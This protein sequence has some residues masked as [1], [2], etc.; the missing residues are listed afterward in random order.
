MHKVIFIASTGFSGSTMLDLMLSN[1]SKGFSCGEIY[2]Y[3]NPWRDHHFNP[4]CGCGNLS[5]ALWARLKNNYHAERIYQ[6]LF[7]EFPNLEFVV[8]SSKDPTWIKDQLIHTTANGLHPIP[9][10]LWKDPIDYAYSCW[11]RG[12]DRNWQIRW[13]NYYKILFSITDQWY[14]VRYR[15]LAKFPAQTLESLCNV[16]DIE[17]FPGKELFWKKIHHNL[18]GSNTVKFQFLERDSTEFNRMK[19]VQLTE[20]KNLSAD[21]VEESI[22]HQKIYYRNNF[23]KSFPS[24]N[25]KIAQENAQIQ[26]IKEILISTDFRNF[27]ETKE[28][29]ISSN[30]LNS[31]ILWYWKYKMINRA[32]RVRALIRS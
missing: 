18:F 10:L 30:E 27:D 3:F 12:K 21:Q 22:N 17:Y 28:N 20:K 29:V 13:V 24:I 31:P 7:N 4:V 19:T 15:D 32:F 8:D 9:I 11:K 25:R 6:G 26:Q 1:S 2:A 23:D 5:C 16:I 14:S